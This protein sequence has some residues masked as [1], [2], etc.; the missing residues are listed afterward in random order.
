MKARLPRVRLAG[1][2]TRTETEHTEA[3]GT[4]G[5]DRTAAAA[6]RSGSPAAAAAPRL[7]G[8]ITKGQVCTPG[9]EQAPPSARHLLA[10]KQD[11]RP[12][13][14][15]QR[16]DLRDS[17]VYSDESGTHGQHSRATADTKA[18]RRNHFRGTARAVS[19]RD[20]GALA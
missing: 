9:R 8:R 16:V 15:N 2:E 1:R 6:H 20:P 11:S 13:L 18:S 12:T 10:E 4:V 7:A 5:A 19:L 14:A 17:G 3:V